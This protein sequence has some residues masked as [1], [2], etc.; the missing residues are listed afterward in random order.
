MA[1]AALYRLCVMT[2]MDG[3][4]ACQGWVDIEF[5]TVYYIIKNRPTLNGSHVCAIYQQ[6]LGCTD[7]S[8]PDWT[9]RIDPNPIETNQSKVNYYYVYLHYARFFNT[10]KV[11]PRP[12]K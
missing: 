6:S 11:L 5:D 7:E 9:I 8:I 1:K 4:V 3:P 12:W 2:S 10:H